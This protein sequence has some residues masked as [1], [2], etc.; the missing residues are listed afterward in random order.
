MYVKKIE[1]KNIKGFENLSFDLD[2]GGD[3]YAGW[4]VFAGEN[5]SGKSTLL[6]AITLCLMKLNSYYSLQSDFD[7]WIN[8]KAEGKTGVI[9]LKLFRSEQDDFFIHQDGHLHFPKLPENK[10]TANLSFRKSSSTTVLTANGFMMAEASHRFGW[11]SCAYGPFRRVYGASPEAI[12]LM[13]RAETGRYATLFE[14]ST[15]MPF[16]EEWLKEI[17]TKSLEEREGYENFL[18][19]IQRLVS[20]YFIWDINVN[21][22]GLS[23][24]DKDQNKFNLRDLSDGYQCAFALLIDILKHLHDTYGPTA[25]FE[26]NEESNQLYIKRS[27]VILIDEIDAHLHPEWQRTIGFWLKKHFPNIQFLVTTHSPLICQAADPKGLFVLPKV[28]SDE[29]PRAVTDLEYRRIVAER[30]DYILRSEAFGMPYTRSEQ[31][32]QLRRRHDELSAKQDE[33]VALIP[34]EVDELANIDKKIF[35]GDED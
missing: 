35:P 15:T 22:D 19:N 9:S 25:M 4:T 7:G 34:D 16:G 12:G 18:R 2:R 10:L 3:T 23:F 8:N 1:L 14:P 13:K 20:E 30:P 26:I 28:G 29:E 17:Y 5:G 21:S 11:F 6:K 31:I 24:F 33:G 27:G 32:V